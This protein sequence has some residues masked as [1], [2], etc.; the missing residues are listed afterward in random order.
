MIMAVFNMINPQPKPLIQTWLYCN[1]S[2]WLD[3]LTQFISF[4]T[5]AIYKKKKFMR[6]GL[7]FTRPD[8]VFKVEGY[9]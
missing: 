1:T 8:G 3:Y 9:P 6:Y 7:T 2:L 5:K 4:E